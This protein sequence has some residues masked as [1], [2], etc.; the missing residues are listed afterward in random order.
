M[1]KLITNRHLKI[2]ILIQIVAF[3]SLKIFVTN[4]GHKCLI[5]VK[6]KPIS[7]CRAGWSKYSNMLVYARAC[8][9]GHSFD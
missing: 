4:F 1:Y 9:R 8:K 5:S 7:F 6:R 2:R 3:V